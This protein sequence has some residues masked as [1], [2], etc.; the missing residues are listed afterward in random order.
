VTL[1]VPRSDVLD[2]IIAHVCQSAEIPVATLWRGR[3][4]AFYGSPP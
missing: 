2:G 3:P 1:R 4:S